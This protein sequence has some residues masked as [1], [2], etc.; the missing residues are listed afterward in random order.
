MSSPS[1]VK[2]VTVLPSMIDFPFLESRWLDDASSPGCACRCRRPAGRRGEPRPGAGEIA[3]GA[4][5]QVRL[6]DTGVG[7]GTFDARGVLSD[8]VRV[9]ALPHFNRGYGNDSGPNGPSSSGIR[10]GGAERTFAFAVRK[11]TG[12]IL[13]W[14]PPI[15]SETEDEGCRIV[16][17]RDGQERGTPSAV[18][19]RVHRER[20]GR[21]LE[22]HHERLEVDPRV[23]PLT[24]GRRRR[25]ADRAGAAWPSTRWPARPCPSPRTA[26]PPARPP[27]AAGT[28]RAWRSSPDVPS[29][30]RSRAQSAARP[31][32]SGPDP[33][34]PRPAGSW[35]R[36]APSH[37]APPD[38]GSPGIRATAAQ[39]RTL[40]SGRGGCGRGRRVRRPARG[41]RAWRS[42]GG[43]PKRRGA[44]AR[45]RPSGRATRRR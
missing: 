40:C 20:V 5:G 15:R 39:P 31:R 28:D 21:E 10:R 37:R 14:T 26:G 41:C 25:R 22:V 34:A 16:I 2:P 3:S 35:H 43:R 33:E 44:A 12:D 19:I 4:W 27:R 30:L 17:G 18:G 7:L 42:G 11:R 8:L 13:Q 29:S 1:I 9:K 6:G 32:C 36:S 38:H 24:A 23:G 45:R